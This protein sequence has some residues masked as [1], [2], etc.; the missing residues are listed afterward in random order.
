M[1]IDFFQKQIAYHERYVFYLISHVEDARII[2]PTRFKMDMPQE[3]DALQV[4]IA[5]L[6]TVRDR[7]IKILQM[8]CWIQWFFDNMI[9]HETLHYKF[10]QH[11][12]VYP[13]RRRK[14][15]VRIIKSKA[16]ND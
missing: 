1:D 5:R 13:T 3:R 16:S 12:T 9:K 7:T 15:K 11:R 14:Q 8:V 4:L 6:N 2:L 10:D